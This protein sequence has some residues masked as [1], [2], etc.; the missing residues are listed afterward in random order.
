MLSLDAQITRVLRIGD[1]SSKG[2]WK[3]IGKHQKTG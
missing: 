2:T 1:D 3:L